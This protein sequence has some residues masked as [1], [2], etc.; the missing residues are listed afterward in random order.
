[1]HKFNVGDMAVYLFY[2]VGVIKSI[3]ERSM[4]EEGTKQSF[5]ILEINSNGSTK[6]VYV[7]V[8]NAQNSLRPV[9]KKDQVDEIY[10]ILEK[11]DSSELD[12]QT[13]KRRIEKYMDKIHT[14]QV[15]EIA[16]VLRALFH[17]K[18]DK[19]LSF[20]ERQLLEYSKSLLVKELS[21]AQDIKE[22]EVEKKLEAIFS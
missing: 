9:I 18:H 5:Y 4:G 14:G 10:K 19:E 7:P 6:K 22:E 13:W 16:S 11:K 17:L 1:M 20:R 15:H 21:L 3:E 2:G 12:Y 8:E